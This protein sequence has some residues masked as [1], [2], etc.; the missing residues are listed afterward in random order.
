MG[1]LDTSTVGAVMVIGSDYGVSELARR[2]AKD[3]TDGE[4]CFTEAYSY[5]LEE[6]GFD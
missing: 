3:I 1:E 4:M 6:F 5:L 2:L